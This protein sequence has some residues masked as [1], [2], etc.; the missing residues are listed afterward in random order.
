MRPN[1]SGSR[2]SPRSCRMSRRSSRH[3]RRRWRHASRSAAIDWL[4]LVCGVAPPPVAAGAPA[5]PSAG[6][7]AA[8]EG[9]GPASPR[10]RRGPGWADRGSRLSLGPRGSVRRAIPGRPTVVTG[11]ILG[12]NERHHD[13]QQE[14]KAAGGDDNDRP[15]NSHQGRI[16]AQPFRQAA[17]HPGDDPV[18]DRPVDAIV[19]RQPFLGLRVRDPALAEVERVIRLGL[20]GSLTTPT[21][22]RSALG[23]V[24]RSCWMPSGCPQR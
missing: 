8:A 11:W 16:D 17:G 21:C 6:T 13:V 1:S 3:A 18:V 2:P 22:S 5:L 23:P 19:H 24:L 9:S 20:I 15:E 12:D 4:G 10:R 7:A 14:S